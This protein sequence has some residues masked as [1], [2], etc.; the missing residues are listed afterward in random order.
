MVPVRKPRKERSAP[1]SGKPSLPLRRRLEGVSTPT[2]TEKSRRKKAKK[3]SGFHGQ[4]AAVVC[5]P[6][7]RGEQEKR[8][9]VA[10]STK[11][12]MKLNGYQMF[13]TGDP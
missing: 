5:R 13:K 3:H 7:V 10:Y 12:T 6:S 11:R 8:A 4:D 9:A 2:S 1:L